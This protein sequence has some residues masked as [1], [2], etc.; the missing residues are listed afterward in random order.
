MPQ[1]CG[2]TVHRFWGRGR[3]KK[4]ENSLDII[5]GSLAPFNDSKFLT[6]LFLF[7][8]PVGSLLRD[9]K[10]R[11][12]TDGDGEK[13]VEITEQWGIHPFEGHDDD[14]TVR[15]QC[16]ADGEVL[17][18]PVRLVPEQSGEEC[19]LWGKLAQVELKKGHNGERNSL[20]FSLVYEQSWKEVS[21]RQ[22]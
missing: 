3:G 5:Y 2:P 19:P 16:D 15:G 18:L 13:I 21:S 4:S 12:W 6:T 14:V 11:S 8:T 10:V 17:V 1:C 7:I 22:F 9:V 20:K